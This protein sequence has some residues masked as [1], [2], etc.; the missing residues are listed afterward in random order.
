[1]Q[2]ATSVTVES[3]NLF[4]IQALQHGNVIELK[5]G[6]VCIDEACSGIR[7]LQATILVSLFLGELHRA[8]W[9][10]RIILALSGVLIA[11]SCNVGRTFLL[12]S[13][14]AKNG[15]ESFLKWHDPAGFIILGIC[16]F[17]LWGLA[18]FLSGAPPRLELSKGS[19]PMP[20]PPRRA[21]GLAM[22]LLV[23]VLGTESWYRAHETRQ[24]LHW[25]VE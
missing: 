1:M 4:N 22:W 14:V 12:C 2:I 10:R 7:S 6:L 9:M 24:T 19:A 21:A 17:V 8:T 3:L 25:S 18:R 23:T 11:F 20:F 13:V 5:T 16:F 15:I